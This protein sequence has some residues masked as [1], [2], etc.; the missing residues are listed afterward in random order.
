MTPPD[1][2]GRPKEK[3]VKVKKV[4][5]PV[6]IA[7]L[8]VISGAALAIGC[9]VWAGQLRNAVIALGAGAFT[10]ESRIQSQ[11][12]A[13]VI[14]T[15]AMVIGGAFAGAGSRGGIR[16]G[17]LVGLVS[18]AGIFVIH[19]K[20]VKEILPA[21]EFFAAVLRMPEDGTPS[22]LQMILFLLTNT[23]LI[24]VLS[25]WF[26]SKLLPKLGQRRAAAIDGG[27]I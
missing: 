8:R 16:H 24:G 21:E 18:S 12:I 19:Q 7:Y 9:T 5:P 17:F 26:G 25:G 14:S 22:A 23:L 4:S 3:K 6:P 20:V 15:L 11:F 27:A 2:T 1:P 10:L 13:W